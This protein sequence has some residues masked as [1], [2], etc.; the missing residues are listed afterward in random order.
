MG[1]PVWVRIDLQQAS[2]SQLFAAKAEEEPSLLLRYIHLLNSTILQI[3][4]LMKG[5]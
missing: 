5:E 4:L 1:K 2:S 3:A